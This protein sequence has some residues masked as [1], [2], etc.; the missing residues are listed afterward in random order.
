MYERDGNTASLDLAEHGA[1]YGELSFRKGAI[2][3]ICVG[4]MGH[5]AFDLQRAS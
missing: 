2:C 3:S 1:K 5:D 4:Q